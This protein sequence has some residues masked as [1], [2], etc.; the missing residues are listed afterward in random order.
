MIMCAVLFN[1]TTVFKKFFETSPK[2]VMEKYS[3]Y[4]QVPSDKNK[5]GLSLSFSEQFSTND[6][7]LSFSNPIIN[8]DKE[9]Y[10]AVLNRIFVANAENPDEIFSVSPN[11]YSK[12]SSQISYTPNGSITNSSQ[13]TE[14]ICHI[15]LDSIDVRYAV[16]GFKGISLLESDEFETLPFFYVVDNKDKKIL[17]SAPLQ[18][19]KPF[20]DEELEPHFFE[21][22]AILKGM[23]FFGNNEY[24]IKL[25]AIGNDEDYNGYF[26]ADFLSGEIKHEDFEEGNFYYFELEE[27]LSIYSPVFTEV[28]VGKKHYRWISYAMLESDGHTVGV[29]HYYKTK[30]IPEI[31]IVYGTQKGAYMSEFTTRSYRVNGYV[32]TT[33]A[34]NTRVF[35]SDT[36]Q[37]NGKTREVIKNNILK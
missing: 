12:T 30:D 20:S 33:H 36:V 17:T 19:E 23:G 21:H 31:I 26:Y 10:N 16:I 6:I 22:H 14:Y 7:V 2:E 18:W 4:A 3:S 35:F 11:I 25:D 24:T 27:Y 8:S 5:I 34:A 32:E 13:T 29:R 37:F 1:C 15:S 9:Y 28:V